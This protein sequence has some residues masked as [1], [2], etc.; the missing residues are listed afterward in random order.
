MIRHAKTALKY[1]LPVLI[2]LFL[3][4]SIHSN[5]AQI[6]EYPWQFDFPLLALATLFTSTWFFVRTWIWWQLVREMHEHVPY[7]PAFR[8]FMISEVARYV[9][10]KIWQYV[11]RI[12]LAQRYHIP[13]ALTLTSALV[14]LLMVMVAAGVVTLANASRILPSLEEQYRPLFL[15]ALLAALVLV[16]PKSLKLWSRVLAKFLRQEWVP[17]DVR[18][19]H[20]VMILAAS[21]LTWALSGYGFALFV[22]ALTHGT[23][24]HTVQ[25]A[26]VY[27]ASW[28]I[29]LLA[30]VV[31]AGVG[32]REGTMT[33]LLAVIMP[34]PTAAVIAIAS[35]LWITLLE[36]LL[37]AG[38]RIFIPGPELSRP[39]S[40]GAEDAG[41]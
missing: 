9:P 22:Q 6:R 38:A 26:T 23:D 18:Y 8:V 25:L 21:L 1:L 19:S 31:P 39:P 32:V 5:W 14:E 40:N 16:H 2:I 20:L 11:S 3:A 41:G 35:R 7:W 36:V 28:L 12:Y 29:G 34:H 27:A 33:L 10:G 24:Q 13:P 37:L 17:F 15:L 4:R 30:I